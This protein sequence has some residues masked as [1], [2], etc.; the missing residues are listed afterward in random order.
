MC[1]QQTSIHVLTITTKH[2]GAVST[3]AITRANYTVTKKKKK[4]RKLRL[5]EYPHCHAAYYLPT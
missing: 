2:S 5:K 3:F 4:K 1:T